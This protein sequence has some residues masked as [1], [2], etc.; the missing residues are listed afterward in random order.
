[1]KKHNLI[2]KKYAEFRIYQPPEVVQKTINGA[3]PAGKGEWI[4]DTLFYKYSV[5]E[6]ANIHD[7]LYSEYGPKDISRKDADTLFLNMMLNGL[8]KQDEKSKMI[9]KPLVYMYYYSVRIFGRFF[10]SKKPELN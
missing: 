8:K 2:F 10:W 5:T 1:M 7:F 3:G 9:N 6:A 4:R